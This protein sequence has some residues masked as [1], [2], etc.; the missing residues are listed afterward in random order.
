VSILQYGQDRSVL[1]LSWLALTL[2]C[3]GYPERAVE[4]SAR[5]IL[6]AKSIAHPF[7]QAFALTFSAVLHQLRRES[8]LVRL[9][10]EEGLTIS[11]EQQFSLFAACDSMLLGWA[12]KEQGQIEQG[13]AK[14]LEGM[15][16]FRATGANLTLP[17][18][19]AML[20]EAYS[21]A[22]RLD[23]ALCSISNAKDIMRNTGEGF[24]EAEIHRLCGEVLCKSKRH[25]EGEV[26]FRDA[27]ET[28]R[29]QEAKS[30][31]LRTAVSRSELYRERPEGNEATTVV[32]EIYSWFREGFTTPDLA[33]AVQLLGASRMIN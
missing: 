25:L 9:R 32:R 16:S 3:L 30:F 22:G 7:S 4:R 8:S 21:D 12:L 29:R 6:V 2:W 23:E 17:Y 13:I 5:A 27:M 11:T 1:A 10:A 15:Q 14:T 31:E 24:Y 28:A 33:K 26:A 19:F 18:Y 20:T